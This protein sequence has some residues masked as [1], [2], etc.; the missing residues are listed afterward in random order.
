MYSGGKGAVLRRAVYC[1]ALRLGLLEPFP[2]YGVY[3]VEHTQLM[4]SRGFLEV[5]V[6]LLDEDRFGLRMRG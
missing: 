3:D 4:R 6:D 5:C 2:R 1:L